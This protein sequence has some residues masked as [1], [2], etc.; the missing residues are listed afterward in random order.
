MPISP[1]QLFEQ[2]DRLA[3]VSAT[4][5]PRQVDARR[6]ISAAYYGLFHHI[7]GAIADEFVGRTHRSS[8]RYALAYRRLEHR[9]LR[10][11][12]WDV[13]RPALPQRYAPYLPGNA[14]DESMRAF[15]RTVMDLQRKRHEADYDP[16]LTFQK[17]DA[18]LALEAARIAV[19]TFEGAAD[20]PRRTFL[21]L[22]LCPP[23]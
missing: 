19:Q 14:F 7:A 11:I 8:G 23:R 22:L 3:G 1:E 5:R 2:A 10:D 4:G 16:S 12:C 9:T 21:T 6:A 17:R 15:A 13:A 18:K 20:D